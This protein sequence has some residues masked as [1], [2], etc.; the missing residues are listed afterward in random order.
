MKNIKQE[1]LCCPKCGK[2][3]HHNLKKLQIGKIVQCVCRTRM[4]LISVDDRIQEV[5]GIRQVE[6][7]FSISA[8]A[9]G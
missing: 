6:Q 9:P 3:R 2:P 8:T 5:N 1:D 7:V 4:E